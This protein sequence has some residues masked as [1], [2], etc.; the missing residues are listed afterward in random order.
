MG[1]A[2]SNSFG[3]GD[4]PARNRTDLLNHECTNR[5]RPALGRLILCIIQVKIR[6]NAARTPS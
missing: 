5:P 6:S 4:G 1:P 3:E 2:G